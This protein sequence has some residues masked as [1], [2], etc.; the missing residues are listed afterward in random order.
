MSRAIQRRWTERASRVAGAALRFCV[1]LSLVLQIVLTS[2]HVYLEP[3]SDGAD[4]SSGGASAWLTAFAGDDD[5]D[6]DGDHERHSAAQHELKALRSARLGPAQIFVA[7][8]VQWVD[9]EQDCP[10]PQVLEFSG[11]SPPELARSWQFLVRAALPVRAPSL[12][13]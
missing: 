4:T 7:S 2:I 9:V 1:A 3:H 6:G 11:L 10:Q 13:F 5:H 8:A 12:L